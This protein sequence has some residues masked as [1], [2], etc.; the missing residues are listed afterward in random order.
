MENH[1]SSYNNKTIQ[2]LPAKNAERNLYETP[3]KKTKPHNYSPDRKSFRYEQDDVQAY[4]N[5]RI[6]PVRLF[7]DWNQQK[8]CQI[9]FLIYATKSFPHRYTAL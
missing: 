8:D 2:N 7:F 9:D 5:S 1:S 4:L 3:E 6:A